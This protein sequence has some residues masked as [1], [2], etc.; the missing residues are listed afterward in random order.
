M[1]EYEG[2][3]DFLQMWL[4]KV[5]LISTE[6][7]PKQQAKITKAG[8]DAYMQKLRAV[9]REKHYSSHKDKTYGH[10]ADH[11][12][13]Q[14]KDVDGNVTGVSSIGWDNP[15]HAMNMTRLNDGT[16][17]IRGDHFIT[18]LQQSEEVQE[19][20]LKAESA[21]YQKLIQKEGDDL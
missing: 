13:N 11:I 8:A 1:A 18:N 14:A 17:K 19:D 5:K 7:T 15:Y 10:A 21:E 20:V 9:T 16:R 2:M 3:D 4:K 12:T 6:L